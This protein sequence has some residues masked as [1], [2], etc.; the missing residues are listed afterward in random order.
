MLR[1]IVGE[2]G[3][4]DVA[5]EMVD[6]DQRQAVHPCQRL[7]QRAAD[8]QRAHQTG[9]LRHRQAVEIAEAHAGLGQRLLDDR[10]DDLDV[11]PR[12]ELRHHAAVGRVD[13]VLRGDHARQHAPAVDEHGGRRLVARALDPEHELPHPGSPYSLAPRLP[14][15]RAI[16]SAETKGD[17]GRAPRV[18]PAPSPLASPVVSSATVVACPPGSGRRSAWAR[19]AAAARR[20]SCP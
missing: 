10:H 18:R 14:K 3:G 19:P 12:G 8:Q 9:A 20:S 6:A 5:L 17:A 7:G 2:E 15:F 13:V 1:R 4:I 11:P 16:A